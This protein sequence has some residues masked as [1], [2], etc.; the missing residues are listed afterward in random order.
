MLIACDACRRQYDVGDRPVGSKIR[1]YCGKV[2]VVPD[3]QVRPAVM[4][5]CS[6]CG[7]RLRKG[8]TRCDFCTS[9]VTLGERGWGEACPQCFARMVKDA[10]FCS[11]CGTTIDPHQVRKSEREEICP[12][13][14]EPM[15]LCEGP[16]ATWV[17]CTSCGGVWL[18]QEIFRKV[19]DDQKDSG[20]AA[21][22]TSSDGLAG[23][24]PPGS[25]RV[26][27]VY[28][29]CPVCSKMMNRRNFARSSNVVIDSCRSHGL[30]F[31]AHELERILLF[32]RDGGL[33][34]SRKVEEMKAQVEME[35]LR[36]GYGTVE[37]PGHPPRGPQGGMF[38]A[39]RVYSMTIS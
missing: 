34:R 33:E 2:A 21:L 3:V 19:V 4:Q 10:S 27:V 5:R 31:D 12:V 16:G 20:L 23:G 9:E 37:L 28:R 39:L 36:Y 24:R 32:V 13:C 35:R 6:S 25:G 29:K 22:F 38:E 1:C 8:A 30:W 11:T 7:A 15:S 17:E 26:E 18:D 14:E